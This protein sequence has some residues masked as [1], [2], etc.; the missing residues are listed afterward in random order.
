MAV[1][2]TAFDRIT[3]SWA[4]TESIKQQSDIAYISK[5][6]KLREDLVCP[7]TALYYTPLSLNSK[8]L[9]NFSPTLLSFPH[10]SCLN[11]STIFPRETPV[12][13][14]GGKCCAGCTLELVIFPG[15]LCEEMII[16]GQGAERIHS[17]LKC[18]R[19]RK[20]KRD[21]RW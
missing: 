5:I 6:N 10:Y 11:R 1:E 12:K 21:K 14:R 3:F 4:Q 13:D 8:L 17:A 2:I 7:S 9:H 19:H 20:R 16:V 18:E 15:L